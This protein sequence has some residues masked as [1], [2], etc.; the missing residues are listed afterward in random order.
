MPTL[1][2]EH[3]VRDFD[4][5]KRAFDSDPV[6]REQGG[7]RSYRILRPVDDPKYVVV[8]LEF[9]AATDAEAFHGAL[10]ELWKR[11]E[12]EGL[13]S[14]PRGRVLDTAEEHAY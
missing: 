6:G 5:W 10:R 8:E 4:S 9:D 7:V 12:A 2:I 14:G 3:T 1:Q 13:V 11:I